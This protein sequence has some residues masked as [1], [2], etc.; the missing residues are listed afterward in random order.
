MTNPAHRLAVYAALLGLLA[1]ATGCEQARQAVSRMT[2]GKPGQAEWA[3]AEARGGAPVAGPRNPQL[4]WEYENKDWEIQQALPLDDGFILGCKRTPGITGEANLWENDKLWDE[5]VDKLS[6]GGHARGGLLRLDSSGKVAGKLELPPREGKSYWND[7]SFA[8]GRGA[9]PQLYALCSYSYNSLFSTSFEDMTKPDFVGKVER[10]ARLLAYDMELNLLWQL[11]LPDFGGSFGGVSTGPDGSVYL[12]LAGSWKMDDGVDEPVRLLRI[13]PDGEQRESY[14]FPRARSMG[15]KTS[16]PVD[17]VAGTRGFTAGGG[18]LV[19]A[20]TPA[21]LGRWTPALKLEWNRDMVKQPQGRPVALAS[22]AV[23]VL[24][25]EWDHTDDASESLKLRQAAQT[26]ILVVYDRFGTEVQR[27]TIEDDNARIAAD[28]RGNLLLLTNQGEERL[29][30]QFN[31]NGVRNWEY[32]FAPDKARL[33]P[34]LLGPLVDGDGAAYCWF[35]RGLLCVNPDGTE[36]YMQ[37]VAPAGDSEW[38]LAGG[39]SLGPGGNLVIHG[40]HRVALVGDGADGA[41]TGEA[42]PP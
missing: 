28:A 39:V 18:G 38:R 15:V 26:S 17:W 5:M 6:A 22:G 16:L 13:S 2:G 14:D 24:L 35:G 41:A 11:D 27:R 10:H 37:M 12:D 40:S 25:D 7:F 31:P 23:A 1:V 9:R 32:R 4:L 20:R 3:A 33:G 42:A 21:Q 34:V 36:R 19:S 30:E 29:L 8:I